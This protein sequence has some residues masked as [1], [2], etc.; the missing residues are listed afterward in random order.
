MLQVI[1]AVYE[2]GILRPLQKLDLTEAEVVQVTVEAVRSPGENGS[3]SGSAADPL[4]G[5]RKATGIADLA[6]RF[7]DYRFGSSG[8]S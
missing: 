1:E 3:E 8:T 7:D 6:K 4:E 2:N 5:L